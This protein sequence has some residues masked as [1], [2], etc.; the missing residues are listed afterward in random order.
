MGCCDR[1]KNIGEC[2]G[3]EKCDNAFFYCLRQSNTAPDDDPSS[4]RL[5]GFHNVNGIT[6]AAN[7]DGETID[8]TRD[9]VLGQPNPLKLAGITPKWMVLRKI[10]K[11]ICTVKPVYSIVTTS[12]PPK[13]CQNQRYKQY[14]DITKWSLKR[15]GL[16]IA[17]FSPKGVREVQHHS[18]GAHFSFMWLKN[19][20]F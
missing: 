9:R 14:W 12:G 7:P 19:N 20:V 3:E 15:D 4:P 1:F 16:L 5:C 6:T 8:F 11:L 18:D 13:L 17:G 10:I 2:S